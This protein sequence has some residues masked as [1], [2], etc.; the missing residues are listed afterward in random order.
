MG[1]VETAR[2][3]MLGSSTSRQHTAGGWL[4][5]PVL[6]DREQLMG[7]LTKA[8]LQELICINVAVAET[9]ALLS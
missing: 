7:Q 1:A 3:R 5:P 4:K 9:A 8:L 2:H 6:T